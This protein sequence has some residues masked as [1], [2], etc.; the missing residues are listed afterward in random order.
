[1]R[2][3][4]TTVLTGCVMCTLILFSAC[5]TEPYQLTVLNTPDPD[6]TITLTLPRPLVSGKPYNE[7]GFL[8]NKQAGEIQQG[9][10]EANPAFLY[11][12]VGENCLII[13]QADAPES[14]YLLITSSGIGKTQTV[15]VDSVVNIPLEGGDTHFN[16]PFPVKYLNWGGN[17]DGYALKIILGQAYQLNVAAQAIREYYAQRDS[18]IIEDTADGF[19]LSQNQPYNERGDTQLMELYSFQF[20]QK[21]GGTYL[22]VTTQ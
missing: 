15:L 13:R 16:F 22:T 6:K 17:L 11:E 2:K 1:M 18:F 14:E 19:R 5:G 21:D 10:R 8:S 20:Q 12:N 7:S 4:I 9:I 3:V